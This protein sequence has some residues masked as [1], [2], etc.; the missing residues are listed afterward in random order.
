MYRSKPPTCSRIGLGGVKSLS[1]M[2]CFTAAHKR[3]LL[4]TLKENLKRLLATAGMLLSANDTDRT[5]STRTR[6]TSM[7]ASEIFIS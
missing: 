2:V 5:S 3:R 1:K 7:S 6:C 4:D